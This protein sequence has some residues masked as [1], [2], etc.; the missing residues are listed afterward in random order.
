M[1]LY[2]VL[3]PHTSPCGPCSPVLNAR[4]PPLPAPF[5]MASKFPFQEFSDVEPSCAKEKNDRKELLAVKGRKIRR[6]TYKRQKTR[7]RFYSLS[8]NL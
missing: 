5:H 4:K 3:P 1:Q 2:A 6:S 8:T 7:M